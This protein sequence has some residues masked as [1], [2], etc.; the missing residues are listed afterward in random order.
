MG[1]FGKKKEAPRPQGVMLGGGHHVDVVGE[2][3]YQDALERA[4]GGRSSQGASCEVTAFLVP[5]PNNQWDPNAVG[6]YLDEGAGG[7]FVKVGH[8]S[9]DV[10]V[11]YKQT[12][13]MLWKKNYWGAVKATIVGGWERGNDKGHFGIS[14]DLGSPPDCLPPEFR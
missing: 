10:A 5:E 14:L 13:D 3:H 8:L 6:V 4:C 9:K 7:G 2:S 1:L 11:L 12:G